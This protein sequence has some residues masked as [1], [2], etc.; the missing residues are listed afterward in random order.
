M[1]SVLVLWLRRVQENL[2]ELWHLRGGRLL[3]EDAKLLQ[4]LTQLVWD[5]AEAPVRLER[6]PP[7]LLQGDGSSAA[8]SS[9]LT[10]SC[11]LEVHDHRVSSKA[12]IQ[13]GV[14]TT[15]ISVSILPQVE[16]VSEFIQSSFRV[17]LEIYHLECQ[18]FEDQERPLYQQ[19]LQRA[20]SMPWQIKAR[21]VPL[22][23]LVPYV[24]SQQ[25]G[26][27]RVAS[28]LVV[29]WMEVTH[30]LLMA[31]PTG[32]GRL[33]HAATAPPELPGHQPPVP[34]GHR[35][36]QGPGAAAVLPGAG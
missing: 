21:Y 27:G 33:P 17:L 36:L 24:G 35:A 10:C 1:L 15:L 8:I 4:K 25:V 20:V 6:A 23:A 5:N 13:W 14:G 19:M 29:Q 9:S 31:F 3:A 28:L 18:H 30:R 2:P 11:L 16:G 34:H 7:A 26:D 32:A 12:G 22:C